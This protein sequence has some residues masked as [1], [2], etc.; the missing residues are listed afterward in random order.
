MANLN[1]SW[2]SAQA[3]FGLSASLE[4]IAPIVS[5]ELYSTMT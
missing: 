2:E 1:A 3:A 5:T 4:D